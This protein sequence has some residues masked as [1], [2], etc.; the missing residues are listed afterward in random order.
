M[1][2]MHFIAAILCVLVGL[3]LSLLGGGGSVLVV[4]ILVYVGK[5][6]IKESIA[7]S[8]LIVGLSSAMASMKYFRQGFVNVRLVILFVVP[9]VLASFF[10]ARLSKFVSGPQ[11]LLMFGV[12]MM[13]I[14]FVLY[15]KSSSCAQIPEKITCRPHFALST[16]AGA[17]IGFLTGLL[18]VG[19]GFLIVPAITLLMKCS[20]YTAIGTSLAIMAVNSLTGFSGYLSQM[21][22]DL[23]LSVLILSAMFAGNVLGAR[24][25]GRFNATFLQKAFAVL[26][27][28][29][30]FILVV[31]HFPGLYTGGKP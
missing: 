2:S 5:V 23:P 16:A 26:I 17:G 6:P 9:G 24:I 11:L 27:F 25:S 19:G 18:G 3:S 13:V 10:G 8:L 20:L 1:E 29:V 7:M 22:L 4:P 14:A 12:L 30:G 21:K 28:L 15:K 31:Q